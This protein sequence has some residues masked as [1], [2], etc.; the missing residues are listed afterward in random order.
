MHQFFS[1]LASAPETYARV[2]LAILRYAMPV[3]SGLLLW[4]CAKPL[5]SFRREPELWAWLCLPDGN[6]LPITHWENVIG[7]STQ[8]YCGGF[9]HHIP[10]P[11]RPYPL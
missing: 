2:Y 10:E 8:R 7:R 9:S 4:R 1:A 5:L 3:F 6:K 11:R